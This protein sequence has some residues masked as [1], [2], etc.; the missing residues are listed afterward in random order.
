[1]G[2][3]RATLAGLVIWIA[4]ATSA[5]A[6]SATVE[7]NTFWQNVATRA[8]AAV[9]AGTETNAVYETLRSRLV[10]FRRE[11]DQARSANSDRIDALRNQIEALGPV[12]DEGEVE[13]AGIVNRRADLQK[14]LAEIQAPDQAAQEA[15]TRADGL[16]VGIDRIIRERQK[17][18]L[19]KIGP[20]P[21]NPVAWPTATEEFGQALAGLAAERRVF[22]DA[23]LM[24]QARENLPIV[25]VLL[26]I[27]IVLISRGRSWAAW[28]GEEMRNLG[29]RGTG[30][31]DF[32]VSL[33]RIIL[34][35]AGLY[36][37]TKALF[38]TG[39]VGL[40]WTEIL[41]QLTFWGAIILGFRWLAERLFS[42]NNDQTVLTL[43]PEH[44]SEARFYA[45]LLAVLFVARN[46]LEQLNAQASISDASQV[47]I[48]FPVE[49]ATGLVLFRF[50]YLL[51]QTMSGT[52]A[53]GAASTSLASGLARVLVLIGLAVQVAAVVAPVMGAIGYA[54]VG[55]LLLYPTVLSLG[56][57]GCVLAL[58]RFGADLFGWISGR[59]NEGRDSLFV[60]LIN[61]L[62]LLFSV[63]VLALI[64]GARTADLTE[65]WAEFL[66][67]FQIG[68]ARISPTD[69]V[70]FAAVFSIGYLLTRFIQ[71]A[72]KTTVLPKTRID[73]GGQNALVAGTGYVGIFLAALIAITT[74]GIDLSS[75]AIVA[76]ALSVGIGFGL[77]NIVSN[78]VS[79]IILLIERP[80][81]EGDWIEVG[82]QHGYV[83]DI[84]VRST[85]IETFDRSDVIVPNSDLVS[86][87]VTNFTH[88]NTVGRVIVPVGVAYGTDTRLVETILQEI[89]E[90]HPMVLMN[91]KP[92]VVFQSFGAS[93]LDFEIRAILR[94]VNWVLSVKSDLNHKIAERFVAEGIEIPF[95]QQDLWL[96]NADALSGQ[97]REEGGEPNP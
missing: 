50:G 44:Q 20:S 74:A 42:K 71:S 85:R 96:R 48:G 12:P 6:Q 83:R 22:A 1:M 90:S 51:R 52:D 53:S 29:G 36:A 14:T 28:L 72:L 27:A 77:Q 13:G 8:E 92:S 78:F 26:A 79:G 89:A 10:S 39:L 67:G 84:S 45:T 82:G 81:S 73:T 97:P 40:R 70:I 46:F 61:F 34:P 64:W 33:L 11:F 41:D 57:L 32:V 60:V 94:D 3:V 76:G 18:R 49:L 31:W 65:L 4:V 66:Q 88:G 17:E 35:L 87:T 7:T 75:I 43:Q 86:G 68:D 16:I 95:P 21:L 25:L 15:Y 69:F 63:P 55:S 9:D 54:A 5:V 30:V 2:L 23:R 80:I 37:L 38:A 58:Q 62:L 93:S 19:L 56:V 91:P 47:V 24:A 59:G